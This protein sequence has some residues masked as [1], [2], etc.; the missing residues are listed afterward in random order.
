MKESLDRELSFIGGKDKNIDRKK[1][2]YDLSW[3]TTINQNLNKADNPLIVETQKMLFKMAD[4]QP[5]KLDTIQERLAS[6]FTALDAQIDTQE[7]PE[8]EEFQEQTDAVNA[9]T[10]ADEEG[11][12]LAA[13]ETQENAMRIIKEAYAYLYPDKKWLN[14]RFGSDLLQRINIYKKYPEHKEEIEKAAQ[15]MFGLI[16]E[17]EALMKQEIKKAII[18]QDGLNSAVR[19]IDKFYEWSSLMISEVHDKIAT[20]GMVFN[21]SEF[22]EEMDDFVK[23]INDAILYFISKEYDSSKISFHEQK[24]DNAIRKRFHLSSPLTLIQHAKED[25]KDRLETDLKIFLGL[26]ESEEGAKGNKQKMVDS[27]LSK[28][29]EEANRLIWRCQEQAVSNGKKFSL[30]EIKDELNKLSENLLEEAKRISAAQSALLESDY[31]TQFEMSGETEL[32]QADSDSSKNELSLKKRSDRTLDIHFAETHAQDLSGEP[33]W[34]ATSGDSDPD[35]HNETKIHE[36]TKLSFLNLPYI[37]D[38]VDKMIEA[39]EPLCYGVYHYMPNKNQWR[40]IPRREFQHDIDKSQIPYKIILLTLRIDPDSHKIKYVLANL[41]NG[42]Y[43]VLTKL[44][45]KIEKTS[46]YSE[47]IG[48]DDTDEKDKR[49]KLILSLSSEDKIEILDNK[50]PNP[51]W[52]LEKTSPIITKQQ[53]TS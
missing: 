28:F 43:K 33:Q 35:V 24:I 46:K 5:E 41:S 30:N 34:E 39:S 11:T 20:N 12:Q 3:F 17:Q 15:I 13:D 19:L 27:Y 22:M 8:K 53:K 51:P 4:G 16:N 52:K 31:Q 2:W 48:T 29:I 45:D 40:R 14:E 23:L 42:S 21:A 47:F 44:F 1:S 10:E 50:F 6:L 26:L 37:L 36:S 18:H 38:K 7:V 49:H 32:I 9:K 25:T